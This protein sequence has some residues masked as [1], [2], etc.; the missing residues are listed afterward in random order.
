MFQVQLPFE[1]LTDISPSILISMNS[2]FQDFENLSLASGL[3]CAFGSLKPMSEDFFH[4]QDWLE[5]GFHAQMQWMENNQELRLNPSQFFE[6]A[7]SYVIVAIPYNNDFYKNFSAYK[8]SRYALLNDYHHVLKIILREIL[9][10]LIIAYP[11]LKYDIFVDSKPIFE[12]SL[13]VKAG[14]GFI[15]KNSC[16]IIPE[17]GSWYFLGGVLFNKEFSGE[18]Q[19]IE[20]KCGTC[21]KCINACPVGAIVEPFVIDA[22]KCLSYLTIE[23]KGDI[24]D[25]LP[26]GKHKNIMG[27]DVCQAVCPHNAK[28][29]NNFHSALY[30]ETLAKLNDSDLEALDS[31]SAFKKLLKGT[32][33]ERLGFRKLKENMEYVKDKKQL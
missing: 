10:E 33:F 9:A 12:S 15:G 30:N 32:P 14:L 19:I 31:P 5:K 28:S 22:N 21:T 29:T 8:V 6:D 25:I 2:F 7:R 18:S 3:Q 24:K 20:N 17:K 26:A 13:A 27:C 4:Y 23:H 11:D 16:L 1:F